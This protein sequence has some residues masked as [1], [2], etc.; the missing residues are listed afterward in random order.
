MQ[1]LLRKRR[2]GTVDSA[3]KNNY[4]MIVLLAQ[5]AKQLVLWMLAQKVP[6]NLCFSTERN[7]QR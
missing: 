3:T 7:T 6:E 1:K 5:A 4:G 2:L